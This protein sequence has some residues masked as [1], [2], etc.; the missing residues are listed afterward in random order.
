MYIAYDYNMAVQPWKT[1]IYYVVNKSESNDL[2][3]DNL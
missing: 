1:Q 2:Y 3:H